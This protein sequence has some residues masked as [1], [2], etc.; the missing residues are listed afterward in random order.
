MLH[1]HLLLSDS[2][3]PPHCEAVVS[4][5]SKNETRINHRGNNSVAKER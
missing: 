2:S 5:Q 1:T 3:F 4:L